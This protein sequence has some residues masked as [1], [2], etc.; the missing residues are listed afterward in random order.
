[1]NRAVAKYRSR[2]RR[3][4]R[5]SRASRKARLHDL[6]AL[7]SSFA[8]ENPGATMEEI[9]Q[10]FGA[11]REMADSLCEG[12]SAEERRH[13]Q[14]HRRALIGAVLLFCAAV[15]VLISVDI[16]LQTDTRPIYVIDELQID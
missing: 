10:R 2:V 8:E 4:M 6:D 15:T 14:W 13:W 5:C 11:P 16:A 1:M 9:A 7:L 3:A 12:L